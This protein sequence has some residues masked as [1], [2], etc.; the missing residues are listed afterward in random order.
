M[1]GPRLR[2]GAKVAFGVFDLFHEEILDR[3]SG[4][5][6][7]RSIAELHL[8]QQPIRMSSDQSR[9]VLGKRP[10]RLE[11][12]TNRSRVIPQTQ[13]PGRV[14]MGPRPVIDTTAVGQSRN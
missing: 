14:G 8:S 6:C 3:L 9:N 1:G 5:L 12:W 7:T 11:R 2:H 10:K 13:N 4:R